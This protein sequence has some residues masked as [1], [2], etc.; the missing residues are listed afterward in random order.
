MQITSKF[1]GFI[2]WIVAGILYYTGVLQVY[3]N[4]EWPE[5]KKNAICLCYH[6]VLDEKG[7]NCDYSQDGMVCSKA[8]FK[9]QIEYVR[10]R[11][12]MISLRQL[13]EQ[14]E[15]SGQGP[16]CMVAFD[17][18]WADNYEH[19]YPILRK[20]DTPATMFLTTD[21]IDG[22]KPFWHTRL[23]YLL[24]HGDL[25]KLNL[26]QLDRNAYPDPVVRCLADLRNLGRPLH[27]QDVDDIIETLKAYGQ[28]HIERIV[29]DLAQRLSLSFSQLLRKRFS[30]T[31]DQ[32]LEMSGHKIEYG[33]HGVTHRI[34]T[35]LSPEEIDKE[36][37]ESKRLLEE[38]LGSK[39]LFFVCPNGDTSPQIQIRLQS[40]GYRCI[41]PFADG[42]V[43]GAGHRLRRISMHDGM[44]SSPLGRFSKSLFAF[45]LSGFKSV[46]LG[47]GD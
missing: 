46:L 43:N 17:D 13:F 27:I 14:Q 28:T 21:F 20:Y 9:A 32:V 35:T 2:R 5:G 18:G 11:F 36:A 7:D 34:L 44:C 23:I 19:A 30:L 12:A 4:R 26:K 29:A 6:R 42:Q 8:F 16:A 3:Q 41:F 45:E 37:L 25:C 22:G 47:K 24:L 38:R 1:R 40:A 15:S 33:S 31:W 39:V 10:S